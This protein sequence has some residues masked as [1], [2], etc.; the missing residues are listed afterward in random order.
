MRIFRYLAPLSFSLA[1]VC[2]TL[3]AQL[4]G[5]VSPDEVLAR[6]GPKVI[7]AEEFLERI[8]LMPW[9]DKELV[10]DHDSIKALAL[11]SLVAEKLLAM[12]AEARGI[13]MDEKTEAMLKGVEEMLT[14]DQL[15]KEVAVKNAVVPREEIERGL[16]RYPWSLLVKGYLFP[17][18]K[19]AVR[20][21]DAVQNTENAD[22]AASE[23]NALMLKV[24]D[25]SWVGYGDLFPSLEDAV[26]ALHGPGFTEPAFSPSEGW[27]VFRVFDR[28]SNALW[29]SQSQSERLLEVQK[30]ARVRVE[31]QRAFSF[32]R[33]YMRQRPMHIDSSLFAV[34]ADSVMTIVRADTAE[35]R[36]RLSEYVDILRGMLADKLHATFATGNGLQWTLEEILEALRFY[37]NEFPKNHNPKVV[38]YAVN[39]FVMEAVEGAVLAAEGRH[40]GLDKGKDVRQQMSTWSDAWRGWETG[41]AVVREA[42]GTDTSTAA[43]QETTNIAHSAKVAEVRDKYIAGLAQ[44]YGVE[45]FE[46]KL[47]DIPISRF[48]MVT[49]HFIGFGGVLLAIPMI[50]PDWEW[51]YRLSSPVVSP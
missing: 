23:L 49:R 4:V 50:I 46:K 44:K 42:F 22:S 33:N 25:T 31:Q 26:Y 38:N 27:S 20:F 3:N 16:G 51:F 30:K 29:A 18:R 5:T 21:F 32:A 14:K 2:P 10:A 28:R 12:D 6:V 24:T 37:P 13:G 36:P 43:Q 34:L 9:K 11:R 19:A 7:T 39:Q 35:T 15:Y 1:A 45:L 40:R 47:K 48:S 17:N 41:R 8:E